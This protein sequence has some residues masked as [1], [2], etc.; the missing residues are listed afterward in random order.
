MGRGRSDLGRWGEERAVRYLESRGCQVVARNWRCP[1]GEADVVVLEGTCLAFVE[2]RTRR[3]AA[4]GTPEESITPRK[5]EHMAA[6]A[7]TYVQEQGW[8]GDW[9]LDLVAIRMGG[10]QAGSIEWYRNVSL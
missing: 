3:G 1:A 4:Y 9:R 6:V 10:E 7:Q 5:L 8:E 2:V